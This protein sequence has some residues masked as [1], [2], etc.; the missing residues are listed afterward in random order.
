MTQ[1]I[2]VPGMGEVEFPDDMSDDAIASAIKANMQ[3]AAPAAPQLTDYRSK[4]AGQSLPQGNLNYLK[5]YLSGIGKAATTERPQ[6]MSTQSPMGTTAGIGEAALH[7]GSSAL[8]PLFALPDWA[9]TKMGMADPRNPSGTYAGAREKYV[10]EPRTSVGKQA[11]GVAGAALKPVGDAF[12]LIGSGYGGMAGLAGA[13]PEAQKEIQ[14]IAP[15]VVGVGLG[16]GSMKG[17]PAPKSVVP[18]VEE[19]GTQS[20]AAYK[21]AEDA[22]IAVNGPSFDAMKMKLLD[23]MEKSGIDK[24]LHPDASAALRRVASET[25]PVTLE[26]LETLRRIAS[27]AEASIKPADSRIAGQITDA[28]DDFVENLKDEDVAA[29][30][31][32]QAAALKEAR[33]L[34][35]RKKKAQEID[36][37]M[38]RAEDSAPNFSASGMENAIRTEFRALAKNDRR[39]RRFSQE[40]QAAIRKV[41]R[42]DLP[43]N[44]LRMLG[45]FAPTGA[46]STAIGGGLG[47]MAGGPAGAVSLPAAGGLA[48][49][50]AAQ[51]TKKN[52]AAAQELMRR[53]PVQQPSVPPPAVPSPAPA[54]GL[55]GPANSEAAKRQELIKALLMQGMLNQDR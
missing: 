9:I 3:P 31:P 50:A 30:D 5:D 51:L 28:I 20:K 4:Y 24:D 21:R 1:V 19:L 34:Y 40:E 26:K 6:D 41:A 11:A 14:A 44:A 23:E 12:S 33:N 54:T 53:G 43:T 35:S 37:L 22:G 16:L 46:V 45:K 29:G 38:T 42:G 2:E 13:S 7:L 47:F 49:L 15:D 52:A 55:L 25:G 10:Y 18:T 36:R 17:K 27:D 8:A 48:R 39:M 32:K